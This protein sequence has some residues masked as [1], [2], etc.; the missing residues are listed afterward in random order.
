MDVD[1]GHVVA[2]AIGFGLGLCTE[3][4]RHRLSIRASVKAEDRARRKEVIDDAY[5]PACQIIGNMIE[6]FPNHATERDHLSVLFRTEAALF[7]QADLEHL[8]VALT[9][10]AQLN[11]L[12]TIRTLLRESLS[13]KSAHL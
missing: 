5:A 10:T 6:A 8:W 4:V 2:G 3:L 9:Q 1:A 13:R 12:L 11:D 7:D